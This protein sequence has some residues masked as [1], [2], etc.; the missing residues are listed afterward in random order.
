MVGSLFLVSVHKT[1]G[2]EVMSD[3]TDDRNS[4]SYSVV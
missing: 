2:T 1:P 3:N 4:I